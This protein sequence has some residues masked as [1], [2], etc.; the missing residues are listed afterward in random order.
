MIRPNQLDIDHA[1]VL[2]IDLQAQLL[3]AIGRHAAIVA[4]TCK[5]LEGTS[6]FSLPVLATEQYPKGIGHT[7]P[8]VRRRLKA[9]D[10][11][12]LEKNS[13][14]ACGDPTIGEALRRIDR[15][16]IIMAGIEAHICVQQTALD[17]RTMD[18]DVFVC[19]DAVGSRGRMDYEQA[20]HRMRQAGVL[21]TTVESTLFELC[22]RCDTDRFKGMLEVI[23]AH[24]P[25]E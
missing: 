1:L 7:V 3:P 24:P 17:L 4:A 15:P 13:F 22:A 10:G 5:L 8:E 2:V 12:V 19:A 21:V 9:L 14:S 6:V 23:K 18:Y 20:L 25:A 11:Q 16:Q